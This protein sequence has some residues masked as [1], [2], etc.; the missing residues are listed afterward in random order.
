MANAWEVIQKEGLVRRGEGWRAEW[1]LEAQTNLAAAI[2][3]YFVSDQHLYDY[4][5]DTMNDYYRE[6]LKDQWRWPEAL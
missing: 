3:N 1:Y 5:W 4:R 2:V 6:L